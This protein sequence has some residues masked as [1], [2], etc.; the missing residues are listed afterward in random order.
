MAGSAQNQSKALEKAIR[1]Y[2]LKQA[3]KEKMKVCCPNCGEKFKLT[4]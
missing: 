1:E 4:P 2:A 3:V